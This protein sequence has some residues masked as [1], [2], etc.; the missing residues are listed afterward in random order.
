MAKH[1]RRKSRREIIRDRLIVT[2][3]I[4][5]L[6]VCTAAFFMT[7]C[8]AIQED[9]AGAAVSEDMTAEQQSAVSS[10]VSPDVQAEAKDVLSSDA[11][12]RSMDK[13]KVQKAAGT[14][15]SKDIKNGSDKK[16]TPVKA[17]PPEKKYDGERPIVAIIVDDGGNRMDYAKRV[18]ALSLPLTWAIMPYCQFSE[19]M[20][21]LAKKNDI[22]VLLHLPMQAITDKYS[23][24][25]VIGEGMSED[26]VRKKT[27]AAL[28]SL[29]GVV[30]VNNHRGSLS[31]AD[32]TLMEP[33][34]DELKERSLIFVDSWTIG[35]SCAY[36]VALEKGLPT[37]RNRGF[38][39]NKSDTK[40]IK[41][42]F[43][44]FLPN[45]SKSGHLVMIC[46]FRP[47][48]IPFLEALNKNYKDLPVEFVTVPEMIERLGTE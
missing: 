7:K 11:V 27:A 5:F 44:K 23:Y 16:Q 38:L 39:D 31:T 17:L 46:H 8:C 26:E 42:A 43:D 29:D 9:A 19:S 37:L 25:Y 35:S 33:L 34:M 13:D 15:V 24:Q 20:L 22:P 45:A 6:S 32:R 48:T 36:T 12:S 2:A 10:D 1:Y 47:A 41:A 28:K 4:L 40:A 30:G 14:T 21:A 3:F 18:A